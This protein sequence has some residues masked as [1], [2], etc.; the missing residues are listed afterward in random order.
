MVVAPT[1]PPTLT[2]LITFTS[3]ISHFS[4]ISLISLISPPSHLLIFTN[5]LCLA[6][7][8]SLFSIPFTSSLYH[9][10]HSIHTSLARIPSTH[11]LLSLLSLFLAISLSLRP[12]WASFTASQARTPT[13]PPWLSLDFVRLPL[14]HQPPRQAPRSRV[15]LI[16]SHLKSW[17]SP[18]GSDVLA[19]LTGTS[20]QASC[21]LVRE[22]SSSLPARRLVP[23][24]TTSANWSPTLDFDQS[25]GLAGF[26]AFGR[27]YSGLVPRTRR[28]AMFKPHRLLCA[29][30]NPDDVILEAARSS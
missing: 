21:L 8:C 3:T 7:R 10:D 16:S 18:C 12:S 23:L 15:D 20:T 22:N 27:I 9:L 14:A 29:I 1:A 4:L 2:P 24:W 25:P 5:T 11:T 28:S 6:H 13:T 26:V 17:S 19:V 30:G